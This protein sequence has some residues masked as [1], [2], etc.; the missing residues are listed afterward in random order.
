MSALQENI[1]PYS[2]AIVRLLKR[3]INKNDTVWDDILNYQNEIQEYLSK[4]GLELIVKE[5]DGFAFLPWDQYRTGAITIGRY[6]INN[7]LYNTEPQHK[8]SLD[9]L[10][11][12][13]K[14]QGVPTEKVAESA[15]PSRFGYKKLNKSKYSKSSHGIIKLS[16]QT[17]TIFIQSAFASVGIDNE[18]I[19]NAVQN[20][21]IH[22]L[23]FL[24]RKLIKIKNPHIPMRNT[25]GGD[26]LFE[27]DE[28]VRKGKIV[29]GLGLNR[30]LFY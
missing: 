11:Y 28:K 1:K 9:I 13:G 19:R 23:P 25:Q 10:L 3:T 7:S 4:I 12:T 29:W 22:D 14:T 15:Y 8:V 18:H 17:S 27:K 24:P 20:K 26:Y 5:N 16:Y 2:K 21:L 6:F 30:P